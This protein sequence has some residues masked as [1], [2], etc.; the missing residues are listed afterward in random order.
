MRKFGI[1]IIFII[2]SSFVEV[3]INSLTGAR[4]T[5]NWGARILYITMSRA[6]GG[7]ILLIW[8]NL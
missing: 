6:I 2:L 1:I 3:I 4:L 5:G 8:M 7:I